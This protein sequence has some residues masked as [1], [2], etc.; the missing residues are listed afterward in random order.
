VWKHASTQFG[1][2]PPWEIT[3]VQV[4]H[5]EKSVRIFI[6]MNASASLECP[7]CHTPSSRYSTPRREW[8]HLNT[9][10]YQTILVGDI[11]R[12]ECPDHGVRQISVPWALDGSRY[13]ALFETLVIDWLMDAPTSAV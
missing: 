5:L 12:V 6:V 7:E 1:I 4:S 3:D 8:R 9:C 2:K 11:P 10:Q 13:T